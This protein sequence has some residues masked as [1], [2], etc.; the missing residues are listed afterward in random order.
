MYSDIAM[1]AMTFS[2]FLL[3]ATNVDYRVTVNVCGK[4]PCCITNVCEHVLT[5]VSLDIL[6]YI[7]PNIGCIVAHVTPYTLVT[8]CKGL[9][10]CFGTRPQR[11]HG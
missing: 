10:G 1:Y 6:E 7:L 11:H 5:D 9:M 4:T 8:T 3:T 2:M